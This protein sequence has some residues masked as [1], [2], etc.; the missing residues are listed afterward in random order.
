MTQRAAA[1]RAAGISRIVGAPFVG[2]THGVE[3]EAVGTVREALSWIRPGR[4][5]ATN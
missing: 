3:V 2:D 1:A 4:S 5:A